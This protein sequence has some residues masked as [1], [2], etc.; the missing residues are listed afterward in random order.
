[1]QQKTTLVNKTS[2]FTS[3]PYFPARCWFQHAT[4]YQKY[5]FLTVCAGNPPS[6][7]HRVWTI[8]I[9]SSQG[10][11]SSCRPGHGHLTNQI[12]SNFKFDL[13]MFVY[14]FSHI[15]PITRKFCTY[16]DSCAVLVC[17]KF[18]CDQVTHLQTTAMTT[19]IK[20]KILWK[21]RKWDQWPRSKL[22][23]CR[24]WRQDL[25]N[26]RQPFSTVIYDPTISMEHTLKGHSMSAAVYAAGEE[27]QRIPSG[28]QSTLFNYL[29]TGNYKHYFVD[30]LTIFQ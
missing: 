2:N 19:F 14:I 22:A 16:Q 5:T 27:I 4:I 10:T 15:N 12:L 7:P 6:T 28:K 13:D 25:P 24:L 8:R 23:V 17:A 30:P 18:R 1:M 9:E 26:N 11:S 20:F 29:V 21:Y 3:Q